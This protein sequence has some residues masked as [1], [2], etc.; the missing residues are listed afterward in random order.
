MQCSHYFATT[1]PG[2]MNINKMFVRD[3]DDQDAISMRGDYL[4]YYVI[5]E[6]VCQANSH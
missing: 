1:W 6:D 2:L 3:Q 5:G 4:E